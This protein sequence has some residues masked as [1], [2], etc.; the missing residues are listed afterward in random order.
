M[1]KEK[2]FQRSNSNQ[3]P[4]RCPILNF[5]QRRAWTILLFSY[6]DKISQEEN[7]EKIYDYLINS[8]DIPTDFR[9]RIQ[10]L[11]KVFKNEKLH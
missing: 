11:S 3:L 6:P 10:A 2:Y 9:K 7:S 5:C 1:D 4:L 8:G